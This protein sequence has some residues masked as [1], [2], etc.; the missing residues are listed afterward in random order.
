MNTQQ[1]STSNTSIPYAE[2]NPFPHDGATYE[3]KRPERY[4]YR[5][6]PLESTVILTRDITLEDILYALS[7]RTSR[8][9]I[10]KLLSD[11]Q[12]QAI[13]D[14]IEA[15]IEDTINDAINNALDDCDIE[16]KVADC[17]EADDCVPDDGNALSTV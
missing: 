11:Q 6:S 2:E 10:G 9:N 1:T 7:E 17:W 5:A 16:Y 14:N 8:P 12:K 15:E 3:D 13:I 4:S